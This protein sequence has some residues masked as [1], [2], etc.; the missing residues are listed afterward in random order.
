MM[1]KR[2]I[3]LMVVLFIFTFGIYAIYWPCHFQSQ[4]KEKTGEG[5]G[6]LGHFLLTIVTFGIYSIVW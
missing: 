1:K 2:S 3:G 4:L 6:A 5:A